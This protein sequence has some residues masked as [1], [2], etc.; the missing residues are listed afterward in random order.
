M[1]CSDVFV[2]VYPNGYIKDTVGGSTFENA[3]PLLMNIDTHHQESLLELKNLILRNMGELGKKQISKMAYLLHVI[4]GPQLSKSRV[5]WLNSDKEIQLMFDY[6]DSNKLRCTEL[7]VKVEDVISS[8][9]SKANSQVVP[10]DNVGR[11]TKRALSPVI[12]PSFAFP[13]HAENVKVVDG[14]RSNICASSVDDTFSSLLLASKGLSVDYLYGPLNTFS[15]ILDNMASNGV[16]VDQLCPPLNT[17][18][19]GAAFSGF[20]PPTSEKPSAFSVFRPLTSEKPSFVGT[21][22]NLGVP[23]PP[24]IQKTV[25]GKGKPIETGV[26]VPKIKFDL[27]SNLFQVKS[28]SHN[29]EPPITSKSQTVLEGQ[30][31][32]LE[33][34]LESKENERVALEELKV[35]LTSKI[36]DLE[37]KLKE[38]NKKASQLRKVRTAS[39]GIIEPLQAEV[40]RLRC[41]ID[42]AKEIAYRNIMDQVRLVAPNIDFSQVHPD[43]RVVNGKIVNPK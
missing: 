11:G 7:Y 41:S 3:E 37:N 31:K 22:A 36:S 13:N 25:G 5:L 12:P 24:K 2:L 30:V 43:H 19:I 35:T 26:P 17:M 40:K 18:N 15:S 10:S 29:L 20:K 28:M 9:S 32:D 42:E 33:I 21:G 27:F 14:K 1:G 38:A 23:T 39:K 4:I 6:H 8:G 34:R 16:L